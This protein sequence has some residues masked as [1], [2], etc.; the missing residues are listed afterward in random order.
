MFV[1]PTKTPTK[2]ILQTILTE[3]NKI[4]LCTICGK[5]YEN[6]SDTRLLLKDG[7]NTKSKLLFEEIF[8]IKLGELPI[9]T[10]V[11][12]KYC[13]ARLD[14]IHNKTNAIKTLFQN[15]QKQLSDSGRTVIKR[16]QPGFDGKSPEKQDTNCASNIPSRS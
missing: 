13:F 2:T 5:L 16:T 3:T 15:T 1:T 9:R 6:K 11:I 4:F 7:E 8:G 12:C 14:T 10:D